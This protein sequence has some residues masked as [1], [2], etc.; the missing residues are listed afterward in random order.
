MGLYFAYVQ[1]RDFRKRRSR[2]RLVFDDQTLDRVSE[3][4]HASAFDAGDRLRDLDKCL[5]KLPQHH[6]ELIHQRY[7]DQQ[8]VDALAAQRRRPANVIS[9][10]LY[11]IRKVLAKCMQSA[12]RERTPQH[13]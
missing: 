2:C 5:G 10:S 7:K 3:A 9:A 12:V 13:E 4:F 8:S 1:V 11:R 6:R